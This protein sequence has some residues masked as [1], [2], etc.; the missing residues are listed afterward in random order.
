VEL[1]S[2]AVIGLG[3][4][5]GFVA[6]AISN[7]EQIES[8]ILLDDD[9]V[10]TKNLVNSV[11]RTIDVGSSKVD[12]LI[13]IIKHRNPDKTLIAFRDKYLEDKTAIPKCDL[14]LDCRDFT[15]DR[16]SMIDARL[17]LSSRYLIVDTRKNVKY[18]EPQEGKYLEMLSKDDLRYA[19]SI[20]SMLITTKTISTLLKYQSVQKYELDYVKHFENKCDIIYDV[21]DEKFINLPQNILPIL[22]TNKK[23]EVKLFM[24]NR[25]V[26]ISQRVIP[27]N[28]LKNSQDIIINL[29]SVSQAMCQFNHFIVSTYK[30]GGE[31]YIELI[32]E[33]GAA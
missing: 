14:V 26:P 6:E 8:L 33:T 32:P 21:S 23:K 3:T 25:S 20:V 17:Y 22:E 31:F 24:G 2:V 27:Q 7:I 16:G 10:E 5:G 28:Q 11:Y 29:L 1:K 15:Y 12:A 4:L 30:H 13:D 9:K 19:A 18:K